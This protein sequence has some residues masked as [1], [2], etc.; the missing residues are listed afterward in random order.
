MYLMFWRLDVTLHNLI[1]FIKLINVACV[2]AIFANTWFLSYCFIK[3]EKCFMY[4][5]DKYMYIEWFDD[6]I[7]ILMS[8][9][10]VMILYGP[11]LH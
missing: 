6:M 2:A 4:I 10:L 11:Y 7:L 9:V 1:Y 3:C 5:V 8:F